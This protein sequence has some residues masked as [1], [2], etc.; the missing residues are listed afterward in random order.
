MSDI[1][2]RTDEREDAISSL[3]LYFDAIKQSDGD[4]SYWKWALI[5][6]HSALQS[7]MA[8]QLSFGNDLLVMSQEDAEAWL[9]AHEEGKPYPDTK[10]DSFLNLYKKIKSHE[11][12]GY[13]FVPKGQQGKSIKRLNFFRNE[14]VHFMPKGWA[15]EMSGMP[16]I[17]LDCLLIIQELNNGFVRTRWESEEQHTKFEELLDRAIKETKQLDENFTSN[18]KI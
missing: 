15:I 2:F 9:K 4:I 11:V 18:S 1:W 10:M 3:K 8:I 12:F 6:L 14:F 16:A 17:C 7:V 5:S 13:K